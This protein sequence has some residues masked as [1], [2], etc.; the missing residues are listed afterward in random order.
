MGFQVSIYSL[1]L[2]LG[3]TSGGANRIPGFHR[4][5]ATGAL[6]CVS[7]PGGAMLSRQQNLD[8]PRSCS[9]KCLCSEQ[10]SVSDGRE[11]R[12]HDQAVRYTI[13]RNITGW[14][15]HEVDPTR[16]HFQ[17]TIRNDIIRDG[18]RYFEK[19]KRVRFANGRVAITTQFNRLSD[20]TTRWSWVISSFWRRNLEKSN[21]IATNCPQPTNDPVEL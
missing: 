10:T 13:T 16:R 4:G 7:I 15:S 17:A 9:S 18:D 8:L 3:L 21:E 19:V 12:A 2:F 1:L 20:G 11:S 14:L 5:H 6:F